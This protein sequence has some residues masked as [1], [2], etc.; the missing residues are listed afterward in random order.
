MKKRRK[1]H[2]SWLYALMTSLL[3]VVLSIV[4]FNI[5]FKQESY[6]K[7]LYIPVLA[8]SILLYTRNIAAHAKHIFSFKKLFFYAMRTSVFTCVFLYPLIMLYLIYFY[9]DG[10]I[11]KMRESV[12]GDAGDL[13]V[14][15]T[16]ELEIM[17]VLTLA[18]LAASAIYSSKK[19]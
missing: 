18:S 2:L 14:L 11:I 13:R 15:F 5:G 10:G 7:V 6:I 3:I 16:L 9:S 4:L 12:I 17:I 19:S 8:F 1:L